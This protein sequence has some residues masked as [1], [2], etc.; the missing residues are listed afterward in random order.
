MVPESSPAVLFVL[1][2]LFSLC[3]KTC[4][5]KLFFTNLFQTLVASFL[6]FFLLFFSS[7][8]N[9]LIHRVYWKITTAGSRLSLRSMFTVPPVHISF[10]L[11]SALWP[12]ALTQDRT[13]LANLALNL[14][15]VALN[16]PQHY[17]VSKSSLYQFFI[18][19]VQ[20]D[21]RQWKSVDM[22]DPL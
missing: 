7:R 4:F 21:S 19:Q 11:P 14:C 3:S 8:T 10:N 20:A 16:T 6:V 13:S 9:N 22:P 1:S 12:I 15:A 17:T 5:H 18:K 2:P